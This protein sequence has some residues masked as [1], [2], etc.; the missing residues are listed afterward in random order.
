MIK[1]SAA[2]LAIFA[3]ATAFAQV[4]VAGESL[5]PAERGASH[6]TAISGLSADLAGLSARLRASDRIHV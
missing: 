4:K 6:R 1:S 2:L 5:T 3:A